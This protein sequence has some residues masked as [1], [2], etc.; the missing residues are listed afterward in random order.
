MR[1]YHKKYIGK[2]SHRD[3]RLRHV[4][5]EPVHT[6]IGAKL[7]KK[8]KVKGG[9]TKAKVKRIDVANVATKNGIKKAEIIAVEK[10]NNAE[11]TRENVITKGAIVKT[12][13]GLV[14]IT[15]R[16]GQDGTVN[17]KLIEEQ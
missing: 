8:V 4:G 12:N 10:G 14:K 1:Q 16:P 13:M 6:K 15:S 17:G 2:R 9:K 3:K 7:V 5:G 11:L